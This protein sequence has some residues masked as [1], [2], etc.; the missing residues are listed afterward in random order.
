MN[1]HWDKT[2]GWF[3]KSREVVSPQMV[4]ETIFPNAY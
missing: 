4:V 1:G 3:L 2:F